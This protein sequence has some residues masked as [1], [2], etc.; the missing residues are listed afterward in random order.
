[1]IDTVNDV[2]SGVCGEKIVQTSGVAVKPFWWST[3][4]MDVLKEAW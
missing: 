4:C 1:V 2:V 3:E